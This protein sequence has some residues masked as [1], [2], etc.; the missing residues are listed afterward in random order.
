M[1]PNFRSLF[2]HISTT[3]VGIIETGS[4]CQH[5]NDRYISGYWYVY[6]VFTYHSYS[7]WIRRQQPQYDTRTCN[8]DTTDWCY[9]LLLLAAVEVLLFA[10][11]RDSCVL[12][13]CCGLAIAIFPSDIV[14]AYFFI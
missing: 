1:S 6:D 14:A 12:A 7:T 8:G 2:F 5:P 10:P 3:L 9:F 13:L 11:D 4:A